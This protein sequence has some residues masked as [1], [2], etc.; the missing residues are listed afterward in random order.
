VPEWQAQLESWKRKQ[1]QWWEQEW[2]KQLQKQLQELQLKWEPVLVRVLELAQETLVVVLELALNG[3]LEPG[4][5]KK[6]S[7]LDASA[8]MAVP[9]QFT[10]MW[11]VKQ[12]TGSYC[13][14]V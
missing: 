1:L 13:Y 6:C 10:S 8:A 9:N 12:R 7:K 11:Y 5:H 2:Q 4:W 3:E 14:V